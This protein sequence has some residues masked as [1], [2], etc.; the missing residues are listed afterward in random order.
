MTDAP[1]TAPPTWEAEQ[2][3]PATHPDAAAKAAPLLGCLYCGTEGTITADETGRRLTCSACGAIA[4]FEPGA[5][6]D[7]WRVNYQKVSHAPRFYFVMNTLGKAGWLDDD[8]ALELGRLGFLARHRL[9]QTQRGELGWLQPRKMASPPPL[10]SP[11]ETVYLIADSV[12]LYHSGK[13]NGRGLAAL[14]GRGGGEL[15]DT[16]RFY[17]TDLKLH[18]L[19]KARDWSHKLSTDIQRVEHTDKYW[20]VYLTD[21]SQFYQGENQPTQPEQPD[22]QLFASVVKALWKQE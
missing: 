3:A 13:S 11:A 17:L 14:F 4:K 16:G 18:L 7:H 12:G 19:G 1:N 9:Q 10:M 15:Q 6:S 22:A 20:R 5:D 21:G 2:T 8:H